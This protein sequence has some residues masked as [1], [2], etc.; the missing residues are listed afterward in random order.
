MLKVINISYSD[1]AGGAAIGAMRFHKMLLKG[2]INSKLFVVD[3][4]TDEEGVFELPNRKY[5]RILSS[6]LTR[7]LT[8]YS[9]PNNPIARSHNLVPMGLT[10][11]INNLDADIIQFHWMGAN[12][13]SIFEMAAIKKPVFWKLPDMWPFCGMTHYNL[14][15]QPDRYKKKY[16]KKN[17]FF[18]NKAYD[19]DRLVW[20]IKYLTWRKF[21]PYFI[22]P[23]KWIT[24]CVNSSY[25]FNKSEARHILNPLDINQFKLLD[26]NKCRDKYG[27]NKNQKVIMLSALNVL[28]DKRKGVHH[29]INALN[30]RDVLNQTD[31][32]ICIIV[33]AKNNDNQVIN[34]IP[35]R[36]I[37]TTNNPLK[38]AEYLNI[39]DVFVLPAE[40]DNL[41]NVIKEATA[42]GVMCVGFNIGGMPDMIEH[43]ETGYLAKPFDSHDLA[44][45]IDWCINNA[46]KD[47]SQKIRKM[48]VC[49]HSEEIVF[50]KVK[51]YYLD[52]LKRREL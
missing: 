11:F 29:L 42:C 32:I 19:T 2:G 47:K 15:N 4:I 14:P 17:K 41:P 10:K 48:A 13:I 38:L 24:N 20:M 50:D 34:D 18:L 33:G 37:E 9:D 49:K 26:K 31:N 28:N 27:V 45:G 6:S 1:A 23:S 43:L 46:S 5:R 44:K 12:T 30:D 7:L 40:M 3:K 52:I 8:K 51:K 22:G 25:L 16:T 36:Y 39:A 21:K 35:V